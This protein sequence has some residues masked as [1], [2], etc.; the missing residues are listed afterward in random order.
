MFRIDPKMIARPE[1]IEAD[2]ILLRK[3][4]AAEGWLG[5]IKGIDLSDLPA[6]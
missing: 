2:L 5:E 6:R 3:H 4:A 1:D